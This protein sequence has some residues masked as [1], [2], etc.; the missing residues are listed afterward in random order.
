V[1]DLGQYR[2][3]HFQIE[4]AQ[5]A[6]DEIVDIIYAEELDK[7]KFPLIVGTS[8][9]TAGAS[10]VCTADR[11]RCRPGPQS[12]ETFSFRGMKYVGLI[13][14][15]VTQPLPLRIIGGTEADIQD[16]QRQSLPQ[17]RNPAPTE[18]RSDRS[19]CC[20]DQQ[21]SRHSGAPGHGRHRLRA[22]PHLWPSWES[23]P[24]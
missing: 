14:R 5:A 16:W 13:F 2:T 9:E 18:H 1:L 19:N 20:Q 7:N 4:I 3:G 15:N 21:P 17:Q 10:Q 23:R 11:Y 6:G 22:R 8:A 12:W 24:V